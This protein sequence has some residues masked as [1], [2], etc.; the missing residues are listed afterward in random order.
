VLI[1]TAQLANAD[2]RHPGTRHIP[3]EDARRVLLA[4]VDEGVTFFDTSDQSS[5]G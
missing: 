1:G 5:E 4:S 3:I 2:G